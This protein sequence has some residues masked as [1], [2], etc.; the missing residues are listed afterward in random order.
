MENWFE[1][2]G[3]RLETDK[4]PVNTE[5]VVTAAAPDLKPT[6]GPA[7]QVREAPVLID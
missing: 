6:G 5:S 1:T 3:L 7:V 2:R 4:T